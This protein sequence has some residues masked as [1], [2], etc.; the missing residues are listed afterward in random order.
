VTSK[1]ASD[2]TLTY[3]HLLEDFGLLE[4]AALITIRVRRSRGSSS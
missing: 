3:V 1:E 2:P 4:G